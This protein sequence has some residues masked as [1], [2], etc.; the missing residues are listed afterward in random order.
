MLSYVLTWAAEADLKANRI[1]VAISR[2]EEALKLA[3]VLNYPSE[4]TL[5]QAI[6]VRGLVTNGKFQEAYQQFR[7]LQTVIQG[8]GGNG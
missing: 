7:D 8:E 5:A 1:A 3:R 6:L 2:A 4:V